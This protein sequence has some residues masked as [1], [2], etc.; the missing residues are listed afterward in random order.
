MEIEEGI[1]ADA[2][3]RGGR[4]ERD[5]L[6]GCSCGGQIEEELFLANGKMCSSKITSREM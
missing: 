2:E 6:S 5:V 4:M 3:G 1:F